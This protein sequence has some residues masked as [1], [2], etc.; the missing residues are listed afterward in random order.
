LKTAM[1][2]RRF[3]KRGGHVRAAQKLVLA[4]ATVC[5]KFSHAFLRND[6]EDNKPQLLQRESSRARGGSVV[7]I[8]VSIF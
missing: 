1:T 8:R 3:S 6:K 2:C 4:Y 5:A 7:R